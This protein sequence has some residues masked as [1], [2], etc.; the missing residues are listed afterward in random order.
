M[1]KIRKLNIITLQYIIALGKWTFVV[2]VKNYYHSQ[3]NICFKYF[4]SL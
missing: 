2:V 4:Q 3:M 1:T